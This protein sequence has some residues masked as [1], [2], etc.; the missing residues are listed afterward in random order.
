MTPIALFIIINSACIV[1]QFQDGIYRV[2]NPDACE[3]KQF[4]SYLNCPEF[5]VKECNDGSTK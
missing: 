1:G 3:D 5:P 2:M 4:V